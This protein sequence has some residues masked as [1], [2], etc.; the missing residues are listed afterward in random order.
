MTPLAKI[1]ERMI[2]RGKTEN[3]QDKLN[4]LLLADQLTIEDYEYLIGKLAE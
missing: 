4:I 2:D 3:M 1:I